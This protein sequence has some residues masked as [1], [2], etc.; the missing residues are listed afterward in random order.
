MRRLV[1]LP[2]SLILLL[3]TMMVL[4]APLA[5]A[6]GCE[7][8]FRA[9]ARQD[10]SK[11]GY[12]EFDVH[13][14]GEI[15][16]NS[17]TRRMGIEFVKVAEGWRVRL[18]TVQTANRNLGLD[19]RSFEVVELPSEGIA[20][21]LAVMRTIARG[22]FGVSRVGFDAVS[23]GMFKH[24]MK[25]HAPGFYILSG[26]QHWPRIVSLMAKMLFLQ[27]SLPTRELQRGVSLN[28]TDLGWVLESVTQRLSMSDR[29]GNAAETLQLI[30]AVGPMV[31]SIETRLETLQS[32]GK[33][34]VFY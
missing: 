6:R 1:L 10:F 29:A 8:V 13:R 14:A 31:A 19:G 32:T 3:G 30:Q 33:P 25:D 27:E 23:Q 22:K 12:Y 5:Q 17:I 16:A 21:D 7:P 24:D 34:E 11:N 18:P 2:L 28:R 4:G 15:A 9:S 26:T 20:D